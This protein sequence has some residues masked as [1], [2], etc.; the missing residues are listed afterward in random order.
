MLLVTA[1]VAF[2]NADAGASISVG[3]AVA[4]RLLAAPSFGAVAALASGCKTQWRHARSCPVRDAQRTHERVRWRSGG[5]GGSA[6]IGAKR[7]HKVPAQM[8]QG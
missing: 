1:I 2:G 5:G 3:A 8:W 6:S 4:L 7:S